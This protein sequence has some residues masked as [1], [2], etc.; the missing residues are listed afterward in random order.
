MPDNPTQPALLLETHRNQTLFS[1]YYL[2][3]RVRE[4]PEWRAATAE[5]EA[6]LAGIAAR[7]KS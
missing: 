7:C 2:N 5:A 3:N 1:D 6:A 4:R